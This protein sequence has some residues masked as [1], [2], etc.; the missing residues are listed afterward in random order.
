MTDIIAPGTPYSFASAPSTYDLSRAN[1]PGLEEAYRSYSALSS[2]PNGY[3]Y[4]VPI[5]ALV[6]GRVIKQLMLERREYNRRIKALDRETVRAERARSRSQSRRAQRKNRK[7]Q[8]N[9][10]P[11]VDVNN[12]SRVGTPVY[13]S[14]SSCP[15]CPNCTGAY[16][17]E[18]VNNAYTGYGD[19][20][21]TLNGIHGYN[22]Y[23]SYGGLGYNYNIMQNPYSG[24]NYGN[25]QNNN[26]NYK[27]LLTNLRGW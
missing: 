6:N 27:S 14:Y 10:Q 13:P 5:G 22:N 8:E 16:R 17:N 4:D 24:F 15:G 19:Y 11:P 23:N 2:I 7:E 3:G 1:T 26:N 25:Y 20:G 9:S 21:S 12:Y 18:A